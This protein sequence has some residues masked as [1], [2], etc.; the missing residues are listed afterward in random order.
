MAGS[1]LVY[2]NRTKDIRHDIPDLFIT[3]KKPHHKA[4][5]Q[6]VSR[7][8]KNILKEGGIDTNQCTAHSTRHAS[9][10]AAYRSGVNIE[11]IRA[12]AGWSERSRVFAKFYNRL[13]VTDPKFAETILQ[14]K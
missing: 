7:W 14:I 4:S 13:I 3:Y 9:T 12:A 5:V 1:L 2:I 8:V 11:T 6:T 10:S